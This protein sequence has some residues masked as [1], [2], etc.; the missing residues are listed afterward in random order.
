MKG[1][2]E[3]CHAVVD[4]SKTLGKIA[5]KNLLCKFLRDA[6]KIKDPV[7]CEWVLSKEDVVKQVVALLP[8]ITGQQ[9]AAFAKLFGVEGK[10]GDAFAALGNGKLPQEELYLSLAL[11][12]TESV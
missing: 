3:A 8:N 11:G 6:L 10:H 5:A 12:A 1:V 7:A 4:K 2:I 9:Y